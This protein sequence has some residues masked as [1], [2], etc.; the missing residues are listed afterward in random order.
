MS[1]SRRQ[2]RL[3]YDSPTTENTSKVVISFA[4]Q[5]SARAAFQ[6]PRGLTADSCREYGVHSRPTRRRSVMQGVQG[7]GS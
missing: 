7:I 1:P 6:S 4:E 2:T 3:A 5:N